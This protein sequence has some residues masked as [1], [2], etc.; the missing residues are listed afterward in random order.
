MVQCPKQ[1][2][3]KKPNMGFLGPEESGKVF[4]SVRPYMNETTSVTSIYL[5]SIFIVEEGSYIFQS[6]CN[7]APYLGQMTA[8]IAATSTAALIHLGAAI[9]CINFSQTFPSQDITDINGASCCVEKQ[10]IVILN[11]FNKLKAMYDYFIQKSKKN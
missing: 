9:W 2:H 10:I 5:I 8:P 3:H 1:S 4:S 6:L 7:C 11:Q